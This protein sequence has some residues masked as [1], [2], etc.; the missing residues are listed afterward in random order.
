MANGIPFIFSHSARRPSRL[1]GRYPRPDDRQKPA[2][3]QPGFTARDEEN[4]SPLVLGRDDLMPQASATSVRTGHRTAVDVVCVVVFCTIGRPQS[5]R[6]NHHRRRR[7][8]G[9]AIP[10]R[11]RRRVARGTGVA[12][13][14]STRTDRADHL[15]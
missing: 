14:C 12:P 8:D 6:G 11:D 4:V 9:V 1:V 2:P 3:T 10:R 13:A 7:R 15:A 5:R